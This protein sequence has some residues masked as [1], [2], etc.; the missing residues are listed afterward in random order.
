M[1]I[2][3]D[4]QLG[5][6]ELCVLD[7]RFVCLEFQVFGWVG[8]MFTAAEVEEIRN[9]TFSDVLQATTNLIARDLD[10]VFICTSRS[11]RRVGQ[12]NE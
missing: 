10:S 2:V 9:T 6:W 12:L 5:A 4:A 1:L 7:S 3:I 8:R 11:P